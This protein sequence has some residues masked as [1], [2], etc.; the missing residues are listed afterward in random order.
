MKHR[1]AYITEEDKDENINEQEYWAADFAERFAMRLKSI[2]ERNNIRQE[3]LAKAVGI[4]RST[5]S[6][7]E[8]FRRIPDIEICCRIAKCFGMSISTLTE[9]L[10]DYESGNILDYVSPDMRDKWRNFL[11]EPHHKKTI[12]SMIREADFTAMLNMIYSYCTFSSEIDEEQSSALTEEDREELFAEEF[13]DYYLPYTD[14]GKKNSCDWFRCAAHM[15]LDNVLDGIKK[16]KY[17]SGEM[18]RRVEKY[19]L[20]KANKQPKTEQGFDA[21]N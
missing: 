2:R 1:Y 12:E 20:E 16:D 14:I 4:D 11:N 8:S 15:F 19:L 10:V 7:Y 21:E 13:K 6:N 17:Y 3:D 9:S 18:H 5:L